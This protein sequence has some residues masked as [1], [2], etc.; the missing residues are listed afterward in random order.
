MATI[1]YEGKKV[2]VVPGQ[3]ILDSQMNIFGLHLFMESTKD[4]PEGV[5]DVFAFEHR[6]VRVV[7]DRNP[8][9]GPT[10]ETVIMSIKVKNNA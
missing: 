1:D 10:D 3:L 2:V 7:I 9:C 6:G 5:P 8:N 4:V